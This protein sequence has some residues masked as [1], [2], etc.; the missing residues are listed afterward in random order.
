MFWDF[1]QKT[2]Q[3]IYRDNAYH[4]F[5]RKFKKIKNEAF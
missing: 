1:L 2:E 3:K 4:K 5:I